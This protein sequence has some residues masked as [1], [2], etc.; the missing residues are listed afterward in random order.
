VELAALGFRF[1]L[2]FVLILASIP[3]LAGRKEF[4]QAVDNYGLLPRTLVS[5]VARW[6]PW[7]ELCAGSALLV[8]VFVGPVALLVA[9]MLLVFA[10]AV[11]WNLVHGRRIECGCAGT[12]AP[13]EISWGLVVRDLVLAGLALFLAAAP[14]TTLAV[15][16]GWPVEAGGTTSS[17]DAVAVLL[18]SALVVLGEALVLDARRTVVAIRRFDQARGSS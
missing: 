8:G 17:S 2:A 11:G 1:V 3:K 6:L 16:I 5:P 4:A 9:A 13:R 12:A 18:V 15:S 10:G 7:L 14:P